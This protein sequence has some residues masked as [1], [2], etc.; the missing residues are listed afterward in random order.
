MSNYTKAV[1][2]LAKDGYLTGNPLK[3]VRG[4]EIDTEFEAIQTAVATK[5]NTSDTYTQAQVDAA[6]DTST[7]LADRD[8]SYTGTANRGNVI[9][10]AAGSSL[11]TGLPAGSIISFYNDSAAAWTLNA[12]GG[13]TLRLAG[14]TLTGNRTVAPR[15]M[16]TLWA[17]STTEYIIFGAGVT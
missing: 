7:L 1:D 17:N 8:V 16:A 14:T 5:A 11:A 2:F 10:Q 4:S 13:L 3:V 15:G 12:G 9:A 6:I